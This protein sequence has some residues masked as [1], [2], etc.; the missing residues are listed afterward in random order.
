MTNETLIEIVKLFRGIADN[1]PFLVGL[2]IVI[3]LISIA[4]LYRHNRRG[5]DDALRGVRRIRQLISDGIKRVDDIEK[6]VSE[7]LDTIEERVSDGSDRIEDT[8][9][10]GIDRAEEHLDTGRKANGRV[11][12]ILD[13]LRKKQNP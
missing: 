1:A 10:T 12:A 2:I 9:E 7:G 11:R 6:T 8:I 3:V 4:I 5:F 13:R